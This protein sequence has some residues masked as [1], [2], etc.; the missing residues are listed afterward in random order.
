M[1]CANPKCEN[2]VVGSAAKKYCCVRCA[3]AHYKQKHLKERYCRACGV[4]LPLGVTNTYCD[5]CAAYRA[6]AQKGL[7]TKKET[8]A[9]I[10]N[11]RFR[12]EL[13]PPDT[14]R[15]GHFPPMP[16]PPGAAED[17]DEICENCHKHFIRRWRGQ[18]Y[19]RMPACVRAEARAQGVLAYAEV[20]GC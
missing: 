3:K 7:L 12:D 9:A 13:E 19:C 10:F 20:L 1:K 5:P 18:K 17:K 6:K 16:L 14:P 2:E 4:P 8:A 11:L 15:V